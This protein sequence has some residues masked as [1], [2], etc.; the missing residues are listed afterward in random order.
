MLRS[1]P[2]PASRRG[3]MPFFSHIEKKAAPAPK[4]SRSISPQKRH[5]VP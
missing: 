3:S 5:S 4:K 1:R 2:R